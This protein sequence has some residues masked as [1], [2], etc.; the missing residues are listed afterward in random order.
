MGKRP[1]VRRGRQE[2]KQKSG[3]SNFP[4]KM[5]MW[6]SIIIRFRFFSCH[7]FLT[8][9]KFFYKNQDFDHCDP[10]RCSGKKLGRLGLMQE[11]RIGQKFNGIVV[12]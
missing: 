6:V 1:V 10:K 8:R 2:T 12:T 4:A 7:N 9:N 3:S 5:A 11:L